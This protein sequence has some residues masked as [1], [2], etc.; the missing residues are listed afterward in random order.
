MREVNSYQKVMNALQGKS[1][2][3]TPV[4]PMVREWCSKQAGIEFTEELEN[5]EKHVYAQSYC[6][7]QFGYDIVWDLFAC[8]SES[9][10]MGSILKISKGYPPSVERPAVEDYKRDLPK[11]KLF[12]PYQN[13]RLSTILEG[14]RRLKERFCGEIPVM[15]Y[16][17]APFRHA[18]MLR[19]SENIMRD[20]YKA[21]DDLRELCEIALNSLIVYAVAVI[22]AGADI[23]LVSDPTS[24]G[25][26]ISKKHWE[27]W[28]LHYTTRLVK[29]IKRSGVKTIMHICGDTSDRL[30]SLAQTGV[31]CL[32]LDEAVDFERARK[33]LGS[34]YCL[35]GNVNTTL[36]A[37]GNVSDIEEA[38]K[39]VIDKAGKDSP[40]LMSGGCI[41]ADICPPENI[42]AMVRIAQEY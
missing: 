36:L 34:S 17:Q 8:H 1:S 28:G 15:G 2:G 39:A 27:E 21:K 7:H 19:G 4:V 41:L 13:K 37:M 29:M 10:A 3:S 40:L 18:S 9:E 24:S 42:K 22:H 26:A 32:S 30:E 16:V 35:M 12:D 38:T 31:D 11:L 5:V 33:I 25:D 23:I 14:T 20:M 6:V